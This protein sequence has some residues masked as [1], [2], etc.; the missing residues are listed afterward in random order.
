MS[1]EGDIIEK[2]VRRS[3]CAIKRV[4][5]VRLILGPEK[6]VRS[7][8]VGFKGERWRR[9]NAKASEKKKKKKKTKERGKKSNRKK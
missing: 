5:K 4:R 9:T 2:D 3:V 6:K 8:S 1:M 7:G